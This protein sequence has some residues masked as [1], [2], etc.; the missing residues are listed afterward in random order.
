[1]SASCP[2]ECSGNRRA[3]ETPPPRR[4]RAVD[5]AA[6]ALRW[7]NNGNSR[8]AQLYREVVRRL[9]QHVGGKP[10]HAQELLI[11]RIAWLQMHLAHI[12]ERAMQEGGLSPHAVREYLA[13]SNSIAKL[14]GRL[15]LE[16]ARPQQ[17]TIRDV[18][19]RR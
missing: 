9:R 2:Q 7:A 12:D 18:L 16:A 8:E 15:G 10:N 4:S 11:G 5:P 3:S 1:M 17:P 14:I 19:A 13:W 6:R